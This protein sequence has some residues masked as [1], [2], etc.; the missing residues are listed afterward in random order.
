MIKQIRHSLVDLYINEDIHQAIPLIDESENFDIDSYIVT[1]ITNRFNLYREVKE[2]P[3]KITMTKEQLDKHYYQI[4]Q[5]N[6]L[7]LRR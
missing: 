4:L 1:R 7:S 6:V 3:R 2:K 5:E